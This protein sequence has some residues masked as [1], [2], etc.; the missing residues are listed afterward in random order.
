VT[1]AVVG[2]GLIGGSLCK[3]VKRFTTHTVLGL[4]AN[5]EVTR[6]A[7]ADCAIDRAIEPQALSEADLS[8]ICLYPEPTIEF[9]RA[10]AANFRAG[11]LVTDVCGVKGT[12]VSAAEPLLRERGVAFIGAHPMAG[13]EFSGYAYTSAELFSGASFIMTPSADASPQD[14]AFLESFALTLGF[15]RVVMTTPSEHDRAIAFT[16]QLAHVVSNAYIKSPTLVNESGFSA[17]SFLDLT[18]VAKLNEDMWSSLFLMN[19]DALTFELETIIGHLNEYL[20][21]IRDG[22]GAELKA[23]LRDGRVLKEKSLGL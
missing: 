23:L 10:N 3:A 7:L 9:I 20:A 8:I 6:S 1:V 4:D 14:V 18:R 2:L 5:P 19:R 15:G 22:D 16:S 13:R 21:A 11:S 17:G 12:V